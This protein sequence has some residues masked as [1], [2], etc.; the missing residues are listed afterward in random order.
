[1]ADTEQKDQLQTGGTG[2]GSSVISWSAADFP[3]WLVA[4]IGIILLMAVAIL[5]NEEFRSAFD[6]IL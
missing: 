4:M 3:W 1:M 5:T 6:A 2:A